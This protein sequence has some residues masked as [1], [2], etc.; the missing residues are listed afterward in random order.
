[1]GSSQPWHEPLTALLPWKTHY[2]CCYREQ[3]SP[4]Q[5]EFRALTPYNTQYMY[6]IVKK[7]T[8]SCFENENDSSKKMIPGVTT[9]RRNVSIDSYKCI[10]LLGGTSPN[11]HQISSWRRRRRWLRRTMS[12]PGILCVCVRAVFGRLT[13][14]SVFSLY[15]RSSQSRTLQ[16]NPNIYSNFPLSHEG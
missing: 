6:S 4:D 10:F 3:L 9:S 5:S 12:H 15:F 7:I 16:C 1:M 14:C 8:V 13:V 2:R 11:A